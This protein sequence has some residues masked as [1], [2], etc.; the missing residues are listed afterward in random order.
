MLLAAVVLVSPAAA[1]AHPAHYTHPHTIVAQTHTPTA[2]V[3]TVT[4]HR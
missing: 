1:L 3:K 4:M 2:H